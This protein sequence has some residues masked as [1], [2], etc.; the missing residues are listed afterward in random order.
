[1]V[2][3]ALTAP[4]APTAVIHALSRR[5]L[6]GATVSLYCVRTAALVVTADMTTVTLNDGRKHPL[7]GYGTYKVGF[8][9][10]SAS[11]V[12][13]AA[14]DAAA[15]TQVEEATAAECVETA[16]RVGYRFLDCAEFYGNEA[17]VGKPGHTQW[18]HSLH[19]RPATRY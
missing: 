5:V 9:P 6:F 11:S 19:C 15:A 4:R 2:L 14:G 17:E 3:E 18:T 16:L 1:M 10:A 8:V 13:A 7:V 12:A